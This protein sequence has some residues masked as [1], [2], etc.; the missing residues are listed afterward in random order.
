MTHFLGKLL[1]IDDEPSL[2]FGLKMI[3]RNAG[4]EVVACDDSQKSIDVAVLERPDLVICDVTMPV[5]NGYQVQE[6]FKRNPATANIPFILLSARTGQTDKLTGLDGGA[7]DY[8]TKP[9]DP[10]E[11][12]ARINSVLGRYEKGRQAGKT[13]MDD[14]VEEIR[15]MIIRNI[16]HELRTPL[17]KVLLSLEMALRDKYS[18]PDDLNWL[19]E[20]AFSQ[21]TRLN[22]LIDDTIYLSSHES[23]QIN[24][25]RQEV[26]V[27]HGFLEPLRQLQNY[28]ADKQIKAQIYVDPRVSIHVPRRE[29]RQATIHIIDNAFKFSPP[30]TTIHINLE[31]NGTGGFMLT[32]SDFG[33]GIP[34]EL[35]EAVFERFY[36]IDTGDTRNHNGLGIG[37]TIARFFARTFDG[38]VEILDSPAGCTMR[39]TIPPGPIN[40]I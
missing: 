9:F 26:D 32:V 14:K 1:I 23:G 39:M 3:L 20:I 38:D 15:S 6:K 31:S 19:V 27:V 29:F 17:T 30:M 22:A 11:L 37:L 16:S 12:L 13:E 35:C 25:L 33:S 21:S 10:R 18:D 36:Q 28:Y 7:D 34:Q 4:Y 2:L 24:F 40:S 8:V 5:L